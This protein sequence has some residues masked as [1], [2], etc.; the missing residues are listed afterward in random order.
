MNKQNV[1]VFLLAIYLHE[2]LLWPVDAAAATTAK[3]NRELLDA[4]DKRGSRGNVII[5]QKV[6]SK[7]SLSQPP[8]NPEGRRIAVLPI[9]RDLKLT[10]VY[11]EAA[12]LNAS[13]AEKSCVKLGKLVKLRNE[14][15]VESHLISFN[16]PKILRD[17]TRWVLTKETHRFW[18]GARIIK[19]IHNG[20]VHFRIRNVDGQPDK[21]RSIYQLKKSLDALPVGKEACLA[22]DYDNGEQ[23]IHDCGELMNFLCM[24]R[25][26]DPEAIK[27]QHRFKRGRRQLS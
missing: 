20:M 15:R 25:I 5:V 11:G 21:Y 10:L 8:V 19:F 18:T 6:K 4:K 1:L 26:I 12:R 3:P 14:Q 27:I 24:T 17:V 23:G 9:T 13:E 16:H 22:V 2:Q 7:P